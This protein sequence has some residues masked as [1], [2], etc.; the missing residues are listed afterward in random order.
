MAVDLCENAR[1]LFSRK[2]AVL[3]DLRA[4]QIHGA[5]FYDI[6]FLFTDGPEARPE[7]RGSAAR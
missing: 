1:V 3:Q 6:L 5:L 2:E 7:G 4:I